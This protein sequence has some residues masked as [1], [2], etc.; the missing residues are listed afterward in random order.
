MIFVCLVVVFVLVVFG[1]LFVIAFMRLKKKYVRVNI[2]I[3]GNGMNKVFCTYTRTHARAFT[4][5]PGMKPL[6]G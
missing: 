4:R 3:S 2:V 6:R 1:C 5:A